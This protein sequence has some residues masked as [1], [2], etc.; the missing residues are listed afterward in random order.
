MLPNKD[1]KTGKFLKGRV[2]PLRLCLFCK[3]KESRTGRKFCSFKCMGLSRRGKIT[4][5]KGKHHSEKSIKELSETHKGQK[6][7]NYGKKFPECSG[8]KSHFWK[9]GISPLA[10]KIRESIENKNWKRLVMK[11]DNFTCQNCGIRGGYLIAHHINPFSK[12][13]EEYHIK[14]LKQ[15]LSCEELWNPDNGKILCIKCHK[16]TDTY[17]NNLRYAT[18]RTYGKKT[19]RDRQK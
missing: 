14:T 17:A 9:G 11:R 19:I 8:E 6:A 3:K 18:V 1:K 7:W 15:A 5:M 16:K 2:R 10:N 13:I 4:W 12:I